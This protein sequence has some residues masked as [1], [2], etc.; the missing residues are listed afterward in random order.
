M[1]TE[2]DAGRLTE[3]AYWDDAYRTR[4][5]AVL[6][7]DGFRN[8]GN[9][10][11]FRALEPSVFQ[12]KRVLEIGA[13]DS[14]WL[15][16][17]AAAFPS[18]RFTGLDYSEAG[19]ERLRRTSRDRN[20]DIEVICDDFLAPRVSR[21]RTFDLV[22]SFGVVEHFES[23]PSVLKAFRKYLAP[24]GRI[25]TLI[26]NLRGVVGPLAKFLNRDV[27]GKHNPHSLQTLVAGHA[28]AGFVQLNARYLGTTNFGALSSCVV[29]NQGVRYGIYRVLAGVTTT[30][31]LA[32]SVAGWTLPASEALAPYI[33]YCG[34][35]EDAAE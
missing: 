35:V 1:V 34:R 29:G 8:K 10:E 16:F 13:A 9:A 19:C 7:L 27:Y 14:A 25:F 17:L 18:I 22:I 3:K 20:L 28:E 6:D 30:I 23:L 32:E 11:I 21:D 31:S 24:G 26:P 33:V 2:R 12:A 4:E 5:A 15:P